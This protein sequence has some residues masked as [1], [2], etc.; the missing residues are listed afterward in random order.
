LQLRISRI[1]LEIWPETIVTLGASAGVSVFA[2]DGAT[3]EALIAEADRRMYQDKAS[4][5]SPAPASAHPDASS[6]SSAAHPLTN[7]EPVD[8]LEQT[9]V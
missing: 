9:I 7:G 4:R 5:K 6:S 2:D 3:H 8:A 1:E